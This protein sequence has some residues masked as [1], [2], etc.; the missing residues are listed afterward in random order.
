MRHL[1]PGGEPD[2]ATRP[3]LILRKSLAE[4]AGAAEML[5]LEEAVGAAADDFSDRL[6][7]RLRR[8]T[9]RHD[10]RYVATGPGEGLRQVREWSLQ[11]KPH[12]AVVGRRQLVGRIHQRVG[13][14]DARRKAADAGD[15]VPRQH[16]LLVVEAQTVAQ[17]QGPGQSVVLDGMALDHLRLRLPLGVDAG[18]VHRLPNLTVHCLARRSVGQS[19]TVGETS[20]SQ[21]TKYCRAA[22][23]FFY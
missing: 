1:R 15:N 18:I 23:E 19:N 20:L 2:P 10:R 12:G 9:L 13:E 6:V 4:R 22:M 7:R 16:R 3:R 17:L 21:L 14:D 5:V 8:Q 11:A